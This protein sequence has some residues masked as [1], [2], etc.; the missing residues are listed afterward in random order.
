MNAAIAAHR[1]EVVELRREYHVQ[2]LE[3]FGSALSAAFDPERSDLDLLVSSSRF[4]PTPM[5]PPSSDSKRRWSISLSGP[6]IWWPPPPFETPTSASASSRARPSSM[7]LE[8]R[9]YLYAIAAGRK[10]PGYGE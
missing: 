10:E 4:R 6:W 2:R 3:L 9:K 7:R 5:P 1:D 8:A